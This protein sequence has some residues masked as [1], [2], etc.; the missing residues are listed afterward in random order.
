EVSSIVRSVQASRR[1]S[2][3]Q[4]EEYCD[5]NRLKTEL[6]LIQRSLDRHVAAGERLRDLWE[7]W[8]KKKPTSE[9]CEKLL[10][11]LRKIV[12]TKNRIPHLTKD[13]SP[14][15]LARSSRVG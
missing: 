1:Y 10:Q 7:I 5:V 3:V 14:L 15:G 4:A 11:E 13:R 2:R 8:S 12:E 9:N 6:T